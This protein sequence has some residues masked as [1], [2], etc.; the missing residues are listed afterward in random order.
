MPRPHFRLISDAYSI[1]FSL[2]ACFI[3]PSAVVPH[4]VRFFLTTI[5]SHTMQ[6]DSAFVERA[7]ARPI[8]SLSYSPWALFTR[9]L[10][11]WCTL[12]AHTRTHTNGGHTCTGKRKRLESWKIRIHIRA[13]LFS[14]QSTHKCVQPY[15]KA[16]STHTHTHSHIHTYTNTFTIYFPPSGHRASIRHTLAT[17]LPQPITEKCSAESMGKKTITSLNFIRSWRHAFQNTG[18]VTAPG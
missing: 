2:D 14:A 13:H 10:G 12:S 5:V 8:I 4:W 16:M 6:P 18:K 11:T 3:I 7:W 1:C 17:V 9:R 15:Q